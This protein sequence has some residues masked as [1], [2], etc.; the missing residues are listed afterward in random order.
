MACSP[1]PPHTNHERLRF[2]LMNAGLKV[3]DTHELPAAFP[4][5]HEQLVRFC[6]TEL[7]PHLERDDRWL[8]KVQNCPEGRLLAQALR[9][10]I[11]MMRAAVHE[12]TETTTACE[13]VAQ[14]RVLHSFLAAHNH[15]EKLLHDPETAS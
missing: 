3:L 1:V 4:E 13:A 15:H 14:T 5:A 2:G 6:V 8:T 11:R 9:A 12:L 7:L 10:E